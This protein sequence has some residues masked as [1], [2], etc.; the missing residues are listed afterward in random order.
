MGEG[1]SQWKGREEVKCGGESFRT[2]D[3]R[4]G[5]EAINELE[6][7]ERKKGLEYGVV[8]E[9][10]RSKAWN[11]NGGLWRVEEEEDDE[12]QMSEGQR[13]GGG[14]DDEEECVLAPGQQNPEK[15]ATEEHG[16]GHGHGQDQ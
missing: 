10:V 2:E 4:G 8:G 7:R 6:I 9:S 16:H 3:A 1:I 13:E 14:L 11:G 12:G 5:G 15:S